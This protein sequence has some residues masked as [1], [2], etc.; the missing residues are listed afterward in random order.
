MKL[1]IRYSLLRSRTD[2]RRV[3]FYFPCIRITSKTMSDVPY[4]A[5]KYMNA[6]DVLVASEEK[7]KKRERQEES[8]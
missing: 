3:S 5:I 1:T 4:R 6:E 8:R 7:P 2:C